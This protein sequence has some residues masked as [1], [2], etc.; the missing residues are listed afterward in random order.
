MNKL[1]IEIKNPFSGDII[2]EDNL[3][4][5]TGKRKGYGCLSIKSVVEDNNGICSFETADGIFRLRI[6]LPIVNGTT[7]QFT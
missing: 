2:I 6:I 3:P 1:L 5:N 4:K 7:P